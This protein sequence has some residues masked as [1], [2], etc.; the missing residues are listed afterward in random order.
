MGLW[1]KRYP[2]FGG[3]PKGTHTRFVGSF[4][5]DAHPNG[6]CVCFL[7]NRRPRGGGGGIPSHAPCVCVL[8]M[9]LDT[10]AGLDFLSQLGMFQLPAKG[11]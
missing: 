1:F 11:T 3:N 10:H 9:T 8:F 2:C 5:F 7:S 4:D 6:W